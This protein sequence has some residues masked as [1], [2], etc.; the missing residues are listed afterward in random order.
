MSSVNDM[1]QYI[2]LRDERDKLLEE[3]EQVRSEAETLK[4]E[5]EGLTTDV[6]KLRKIIADNVIAK[7]PAEKES[8]GPLS[9][10][11][12]IMELVKEQ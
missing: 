3:L 1:E 6:N 2:Q 5:R 10:K 8:R 12:K 4:E 11:E 7:E 9:I